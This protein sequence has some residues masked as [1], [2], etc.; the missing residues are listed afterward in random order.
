MKKLIVVDDN[1]EML[2]AMRRSCVSE[3]MTTEVVFVECHSVSDAIRAVEEHQPQV[4][5]FDHRLTEDGSEGFEIARQLTD[6]GI[7]LISTTADSS[8]AK[9]YRAIGIEVCTKS[10]PSKLTARFA[11]F[12]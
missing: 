4:L 11:S 2:A 9:E 3:G 1:G 10:D 8:A 5:F 6:G 12:K 7:E